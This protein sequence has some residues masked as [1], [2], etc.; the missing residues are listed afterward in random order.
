VIKHA[1]DQQRKH[2]Q[3]AGEKRILC[4]PT[5]CKKGATASDEDENVKPDDLTSSSEEDGG[6]RGKRP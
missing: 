3:E 6:L 2:K 5:M 4:A 1:Q